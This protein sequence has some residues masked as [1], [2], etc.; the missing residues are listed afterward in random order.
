MHVLG[1]ASIRANFASLSATSTSGS[2][3]SSGGGGGSTSSASKVYELQT[4]TLQAAILLLFNN[5]PTGCTS[6]STETVLNTL[7]LGDEITKRVLHSL[8]MTKIRV[9]KKSTPDNSI[10]VTDEFTVNEQFRC[11]YEHMYMY[12]Y[13]VYIYMYILMLP[14]MYLPTSP[15]H[16]YISIYPYISMHISIYIHAYIHIYPCIYS[17]PLRKVRL[18]VLA[19]GGGGED[20]QPGAA[21]AA[22]KAVDEDR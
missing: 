9:L 2:G 21:S 6:I 15:T 22:Q 7:H 1:N 17:N 3:S 16:A 12:V 14:E 13:I 4:S 19:L 11:F 5:L 10:K 18:P 20:G 8:S